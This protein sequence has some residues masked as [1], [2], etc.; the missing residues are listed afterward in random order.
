M[1][2]NGFVIFHGYLSGHRGFNILY[3]FFNISNKR[4]YLSDVPPHFGKRLS[5]FPDS[6]SPIDYDI[7]NNSFLQIAV[8][9]C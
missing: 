2:V 5:P 7:A 9:D 3:S 4:N 6:D 1:W 8:F